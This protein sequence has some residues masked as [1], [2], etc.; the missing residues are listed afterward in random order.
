MMRYTIVILS[1]LVL[2]MSVGCDHAGGNREEGVSGGLPP[3]RVTTI[4]PERK[5]LVR[6]VELPGRVEAFEVTPLHAKVTGYIEKILVDIGDRIAG[7]NGDTPGQPLCEILVPELREELAEKKSLVAQAEAHVL[8]AD[9]A[10]KLAEA[11]VRSADAKVLEAQSAMAREEALCAKWESEYERVS[12]LVE[13]G[14]L[15]KKLADETKAELAA[16]EA[17]CK[18]VTARIVS[19]EAQRQEAAAGL[20]KSK[21][22]AVAVRSKKAVAEADQ[23]KLEAMFGFTTIRSPYDGVVVDRN[24]HTG[25][26][27]QSGAGHLPL[28]T[29]MRIDPVRV[30][31]DVPETDAVHIQKGTKA[32]LKTPS[33][34]GEP[35]V[36]EVTRTSWSLNTTSRTLTAEIDVPNPDG[37]LRPG[38]YMQV[39]LTVAELP[40]AIAL[41]KTA[42][43]TQ[44]KQ[45]YCFTVSS[46]G[47]V[48]RTAVNLGI[49]A[50]NEFEVRSGLS[51]EEN[52][53][54]VNPAAF[55][56]GQVVEMAK[57]T[58]KP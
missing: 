10:I 52:V 44:D 50:G 53:I 26:L 42:I 27:V 55:R 24:V 28:L 38:L 6:A 15:T 30:F 14:A 33:L 25:H 41:P 56:D 29:V 46:D 20:E 23:R 22:D 36:G 51:G 35:L 11:T 1:A 2:V 8:Q 32:K 21:A 16:A 45:T 57:E 9:A 48:A 31:V 40:D 12:K 37:R 49:V 58:P 13:A 4:K 19:V 7:P 5:T 43:V 54:G 17:A 34:A 39:E 18:A 47:K 3:I